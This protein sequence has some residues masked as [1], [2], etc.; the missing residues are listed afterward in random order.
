[1][2]EREL[3]GSRGLLDKEGLPVGTLDD[4]Y[5]L[6]I[7]IPLEDYYSDKGEFGYRPNK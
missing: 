6:V 2:E 7:V 5:E 3:P 1:M 4:R